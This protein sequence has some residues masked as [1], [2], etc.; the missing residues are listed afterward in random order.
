MK[1]RPSIALISVGTL[2]TLTL[3]AEVTAHTLIDHK[4]GTIAGRAFEASH[5]NVSIGS[6]PVLV[7]LASGQIS[8]VSVDSSSATI[9]Q[10][11]G[12]DVSAT[13]HDVGISSDDGQGRSVG[14][15][16]A[17]LILGSTALQSAV[18]TKNSK[19]AAA[20][21]ISTDPAND[22]VHVKIGPGG[23]VDVAERPSLDGQTMK[24]SLES[25]TVAGR[26]VPTSLAT[27]L[28]GGSSPNER[29]FTELP[30]G[31]KA[32]G[33][34]VTDA[35]IAVTFDGGATHLPTAAQPTTQCRSSTGT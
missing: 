2:L 31:L 14:H 1:R 21:T 16:H 3:G 18:A 32:T 23:L 19:L 20:L 22:L 13:L 9:C 15:T 34:A 29:S 11:S 10:L 25:V 5:P 33:V 7:D 6:T 27:Q 26:P 12:V 4:I 30:M 28:T 24:I 17:T 8:K 35:G